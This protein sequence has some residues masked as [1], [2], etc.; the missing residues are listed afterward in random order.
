[1]SDIAFPSKALATTELKLQ[2][3]RDTRTIISEF[4][5]DFMASS[6]ED[7]DAAI[8]RALQR[9]GEYMS[10]HRT[11]VFLVSADGQRMNNTHE[12][13]AAG[14][15]PEIENLQGI[16]STRIIHEAVNQPLRTAV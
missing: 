14:I 7:F 10:A 11:Y 5:A 2:R 6:Q 13:C 4:A 16:P 15:T 1:M 3:E 12:W 8:N 9:S